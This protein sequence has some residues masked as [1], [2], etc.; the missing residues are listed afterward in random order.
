MKYVL[1]SLLGLISFTMQAQD[2]ITWRQYKKLAKKLFANAQYADAGE[3]YILAW[4]QKPKK[5]ALAY[6]AGEAFFKVKDY[7]KAAE[8]FAPIKDELDEFPL[9]GLKYARCLKQ[10]GQFDAATR[11][12]V[13]FIN[14]YQEKDRAIISQI[15][16]AEIKGCEMA[17]KDSAK[18][19]MDAPLELELLSENINTPATEFAPISFSDDILYFSSTIQSQVKI[20]RTQLRNGAWTKATAPS[21]FPQIKNANYGNGC[22]S[23]DQQRFYFTICKDADPWEGVSSKCEIFVT[24]QENGKWT[25]P[26]R[27][28]DY[29]NMKR[30]NTTHPFVSHI[31]NREV[32]YFS[33]DREGGKGGMDI[34]YTT[35]D[36]ASNDFDF[37]FP[38]NIAAINTIGDEITPSY[39]LSEERLYFSSNGQVSYGG[40]DI[41]Q[42]KGKNAKFAAPQNM[43]MP[44]NSA[45][46]DYY[47]IRKTATDGGYLC[48]NR[49]FG[50]EKI[51]TTQD[52]IFM[53]SAPSK[54]LL[55]KGKILDK[56]NNKFIADVELRL[57]EKLSN[58]RKRLLTTKKFADG[59]YEFALL[60]HKELSMELN[61]EGF[62]M[63]KHDFQ[64]ADLAEA[65]NL[66]QDIY[67][68]P[69][70]ASNQSHNA[71]AKPVFTPNT[72]TA[73]I[74][75]S[76]T[77]KL[78]KPIRTTYSANETSTEINN[79]SF[80]TG[81]SS[82]YTSTLPNK[83]NSS[84]KLTYNNTAKT[85]A[86]SSST[87]PQ[88]NKSAK[89]DRTNATIISNPTS[90]TMNTKDGGVIKTS[91]PRNYGVYYK[92]QI[93]AVGHYSQKHKRYDTIRHLGRL[94]TELIVNKGWTR[95]LL[96]DYYSIQN[97]EKVMLEA[98]KNP[99]FFEAYIVR[100]EDGM[101]MGRWK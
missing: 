1:F 68:E 74:N 42:A 93:I 80:S 50:L 36:I 71:N 62:V 40:F 13:Y 86:S 20:Y 78:N 60:A 45:A 94:D 22:L 33:S 14:A 72:S 34:W 52:D 7:R 82:A 77:K 65:A 2:K 83:N 51:T 53:F 89:I 35:R 87:T 31:G 23:P 11:E 24:Q 67:M 4:K 28:R 88:A 27:L 43:G 57:Y 54:S 44:I 95:V 5:K 15:V 39:N 63:A 55:A 79:A 90:Y 26:E 100:Y 29:I 21:S 32:L 75:T 47:Y 70:L 10:D 38:K 58:G 97:A 48:S 64:T 19:P 56:T 16:Q 8:A 98:R 81:T 59:N 12:L 96:A 46:D 84:N 37:S 49:L 30:T 73:S 17:I 76:P 101:R 61:K 69:N 9:I 3:N 6:K 18:D 92:V 99:Q 25:K 91:S 85:Q 41:F 66:I